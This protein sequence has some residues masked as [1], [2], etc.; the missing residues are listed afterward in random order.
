VK[1]AKI[2]YLLVIFFP[3]LFL[4]A[5][6]GR[7]RVMLIYGFVFIFLASRTAVFSSHF[8]YSAVFLPV[9][10][11]LA[12][13]GL[14]GLQEA[15]PKD[16]SLTN[17]VMGCVLVA[18]LLVSWKHGAIVENSSFR[19]GFSAVTHTLDEAMQDRYDSFLEFLRPIEQDDSVSVTNRLGPHVS[20]RAEVYELDQN[21]DT[22]YLLI[23]SRDLKGRAKASLKRREAAGKVKLLASESTW[24]LYRAVTPPQVE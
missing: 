14:R 15:R 6:G 17:A 10:V 11:A 8:Q 20:N 1:A 23:D 5:W 13:A 7:A 4:P 18:T 2:H 3:L 16:A 9:A 19:G 21:I 24:R 22:D 12:P